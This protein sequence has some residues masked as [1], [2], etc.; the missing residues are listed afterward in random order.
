LF[1]EFTR[2]CAASEI[3]L[4]EKKAGKVNNKLVLVCHTK[5]DR[6]FAV[7]GMCSHQAK[8]IIAGRVRHCTITCPTHGARFDLATGAALDLPA[9]SPIDTYEL[10]IVDNW[11]EVKV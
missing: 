7:S 9:T 11:V 5:D 6:W 2:F 3:P 1:N 10:R 8:P 4:G